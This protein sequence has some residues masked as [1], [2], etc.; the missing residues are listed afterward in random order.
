M[1]RAIAR[2]WPRLRPLLPVALIA[3]GWSGCGRGEGPLVVFL[4]DSLT[5]G[6]RLRE[7]DAYPAVLGRTLAARGRPICVVNAGRSGDTATQG[8]AR[9]EGV[10]RLQPDVV[11]VALG[12]NDA[13]RGLPLGEAETALDRVIRMSQASGAR[14]LLVG[15]RPA[16]L[17]GIR[18]QQLRDLYA[19]LAAAHRIALV[20]DLL[21][22]VA[23][24]PELLFADRL[25]PNAAGHKRLADNV[26][27]QLA[28]VL[29][30]V[31]GHR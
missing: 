8:L 21:V 18:A 15:V 19:R 12:V 17:D 3:A 1:L 27:P 29:A 4:G 2:R 5:S 11:V 14:V 28:L 13:L 22:G 23:G 31:R 30:E 9:L 25:H 7:Q 20:P 6:W 24:D 10:L 26:G 16:A